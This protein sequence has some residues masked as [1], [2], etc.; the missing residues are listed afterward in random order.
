MCIAITS[1]YSR[2]RV[3]AGQLVP[4]HVSCTCF[5]M[6]R[7]E[8]IIAI[9]RSWFKSNRRFRICASA[10]SR[11]HA[12]A[13]E[14]AHT[15]KHNDW[16]STAVGFIVTCLIDIPLHVCMYVYIYIYIYIYTSVLLCIG[17]HR[18]SGTNCVVDAIVKLIWAKVGIT[19]AITISITKAIQ[20]LSWPKWAC[21]WTKVAI[22]RQTVQFFWTKVS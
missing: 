20:K 11:M 5:V 4:R 6:R 12:Y 10:C 17:M 13:S 15:H 1:G 18:E 7:C 3:H 9:A 21:E 16:H 19:K 2:G 8:V 14:T 22:P